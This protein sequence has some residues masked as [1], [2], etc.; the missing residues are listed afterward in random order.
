MNDVIRFACSKCSASMKVP[1]TAKG[2]RTKCPKCGNPEKVP[3]AQ[4]P[5]VI[6]KPR[7][8]AK[9]K[10]APIVEMVD[11][12]FTADMVT[13]PTKEQTITVRETQIVT[14]DV[15]PAPLTTPLPEIRANA[16][17]PLEPSPPPVPQPTIA[18]RFCGESILATAIKCK[19]CGEFLD[20]RQVAAVTQ[21]PVVIPQININTNS[22]NTNE[23]KAEEASAVG[24]AWAF[25]FV[26]IILPI[27]FAAL[28]R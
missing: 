6:E 1:G 16:L 7:L 17:A 19:H 22:H 27:V 8:P 5:A 25:I 11:D 28:L 3:T 24:L 15:P 10:P 21:Q 9:T 23:K 14:R 4:L 13:P 18:C 20:G 2:K 26:F 12:V